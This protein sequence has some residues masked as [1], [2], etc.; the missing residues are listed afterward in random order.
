MLHDETTASS[1]GLDGCLKD[2]FFE[3]LYIRFA[4]RMTTDESLGLH[5]YG[6]YTLEQA[7]KAHGGGSRGIVLLFL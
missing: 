4:F 1:Y 2:A 3:V 7:M 6:P 5:R